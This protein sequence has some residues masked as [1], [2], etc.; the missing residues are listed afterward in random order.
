MVITSGDELS[1]CVHVIVVS[2]HHQCHDLTITSAC[3]PCLQAE[4]DVEVR[5]KQKM[6]HG[7]QARYDF[8]NILKCLLLAFILYILQTASS[9]IFAVVKTHLY[10]S[11]MN[12][13]LSTALCLLSV[14]C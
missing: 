4:S 13:T 12:G 5:V 7:K 10:P 8:S 11:E 14:L 9:V 3:S 1:L 6:S 2:V